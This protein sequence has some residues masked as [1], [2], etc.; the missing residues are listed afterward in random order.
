MRLYTLSVVVFL[1]LHIIASW[2]DSHIDPETIIKAQQNAA[3]KLT[4]LVTGV[5]NEKIHETPEDIQWLVTAK[6]IVE[7]VK[8][9][10]S[11]LKPSDNITVKYTRHESKTT[12]QQLQKLLSEK[13]VKPG[14]EYKMYLEKTPS[15]HFKPAKNTHNCSIHDR[16]YLSFEELEKRDGLTK[17]EQ[18]PYKDK[19]KAAITEWSIDVLSLGFATSVAVGVI[20]VYLLIKNKKFNNKPTLV[21]KNKA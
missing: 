18:K 2:S 9:S 7:Q 17:T 15:G 12:P 1:L 4:L 11:N 13:D 8:S 16:R 5:K 14:C 20:A 21:T 6:A 10:Q 3:E 19:F